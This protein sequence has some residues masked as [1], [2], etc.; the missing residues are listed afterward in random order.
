LEVFVDLR[1]VRCLCLRCNPCG[2]R[3]P[4]RGAKVVISASAQFF[5]ASFK[6]R[7][8][9]STQWTNILQFI[10][11]SPK[12]SIAAIYPLD[13]PYNNKFA[14]ERPRARLGSRGRRSASLNK[15]GWDPSRVGAH[16]TTRRARRTLPV[17]SMN[18]HKSSGRVSPRQ[19]EDHSKAN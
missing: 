8:D 4:N 14:C 5:D 17:V 3:R 18:V 2:A 10:I 13:E 1:R 19:G 9:W 16:S 6:L 12:G 7:S 15:I 11:A